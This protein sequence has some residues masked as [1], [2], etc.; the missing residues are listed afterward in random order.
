MSQRLERVGELVREVLADEIPKLTDPGLGFVSI[1]GVRISADLRHAVVYFS[2]LD[3]ADEEAT[4]AALGRARSRLQR[5]LGTNLTMKRT[6]VLRFEADRGIVDGE[7]IDAILRE[8]ELSSDT[9]NDTGNDDGDGDDS[10][11]PY[12]R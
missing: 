7:N 12:R 9:G 5:A 1:T 3:R 10:D 4:A 11:S 6:P 8:I 2:V